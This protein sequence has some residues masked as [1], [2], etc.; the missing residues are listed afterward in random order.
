[1]FRI[2]ISLKKIL[3]V[4]QKKNNNNLFHYLKILSTLGDECNEKRCHIA[5]GMK[6]EGCWGGEKRSG[7]HRGGGDATW[8]LRWPN[9][10]A[11]A[12]LGSRAPP[13]RLEG[14][15]ERGLAV[16]GE[17]DTYI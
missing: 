10:A 3:E 9:V 8:G 11:A 7:E 4:R 6:V 12:R 16:E 5:S 14:V 17:V 1:M 15:F 2:N 13:M